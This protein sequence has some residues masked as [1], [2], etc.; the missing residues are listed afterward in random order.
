MFCKKGIFINWGNIPQTELEF[1]PVN[2]FSGGNGS[3]KTTAADGIQ[4]LMTAA[5]ENLFTFNPGQDETTQRGRGGKQVRTLASYILGCDDGSYSR[6]AMTD[7]YVAGLFYPTQGESG[8]PFTAIMCVRAA[9]DRAGSQSQARQVQLFFIILDDC[10][11]SLSDFLEHKESQSHIIPI[12]RIVPHLQKK[13]PNQKMAVFDKKGPYL[14]RLYAAFRGQS[15]S[16]SDR[17]A[18]HAAKTFANFMA[19]KPVKSIH[20]FV[21]KEVL[22]PKD[23]SEDIKLVSE[24]MRTIHGMEIET[25]SL[26]SAINNLTMAMDT[27]ECFIR[28]WIALNLNEYHQA[29]QVYFDKQQRYLAA[30]N[31]QQVL[32]KS[33]QQVSSERVINENK[34]QQIHDELIELEAQRQGIDAL[35]DKDELEKHIDQ[36]QHNLI[37]LAEPL[38]L[39]DQQRIENHQAALAIQ[40]ALENKTALSGFKGIDNPHFLQSLLAMSESKVEQEINAQTLLTKDWV[41][42]S[43][44]ESQLAD[45]MALENIQNQFVHCVIEADSGQLS[46]RDA[47]LTLY[48]QQQDQLTKLKSQLHYRDLEIRRLKQQQINYP[49]GVEVALKALQQYCPEANACVLCD[50]IEVTD[51]NWQMA[52]EGYLG[53]SRFGIIVDTEYEAEAI[54]I[55]RQLK[56]KRNNARVIQSEKVKKD[57]KR[58]SIPANSIVNKMQF[59]HPTAEHY[60]KASFGNVICVDSEQVLRLTARGIMSK[61]LGS[62]GYSLFRCDIDETDWVFGAEARKR[63]LAAKSQQLS[64]QQA[65][66][67][68]TQANIAEV[69]ALLEQFKKIKP[70][71]LSAKV[72]AIL[73][74]YR[75]IQKAENQLKQIDIKDHTDFE[76]N[77]IA[78]KSDYQEV[79]QETKSLT[80][81]MGQYKAELNLTEKSIGAISDEKEALLADKENCEQRL[82]V[83]ADIY[84]DFDVDKQLSELEEATNIDVKNLSVMHQQILLRLDKNQRACIERLAEHNLNNSDYHGI[85]YQ[86]LVEGQPSQD[87]FQAMVDVN[88]EMQRVLHSLKNNLLVDKHDKILSLKESFNTAFVTNLCHSIYQAISAGKRMLTQLNKELGHHRFGA[89]KERFYF[90]YAWVPEFK[91]YHDFFE[92]LIQSPQLG[93]DQT[94][95]DIPLSERSSEVRDKILAML[96]ENDEQLA[97]NDLNRICDY[98]NYRQYEIYK[99]PLDKEPIPLSKYGT[100]SG[101]QLETPAYIIRSAAVTSAF[102][103]NEG[104][105]HCRMVLVDEAF[106]KMDETRSKEVI[107]YLTKTLGLQ[108]VFIMPTS[109]TGPFMDLISHQ[110]IFS[111]CPSK[112]AIGE[113]N[114]RVL[115]DRKVCN[116]DKIA[117]L[118]A[119][120]RKTINQQSSLDFMDEVDTAS[121]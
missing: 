115:L 21:A 89:D 16:L 33:I 46:L 23:L 35:R 119:L 78:L 65:E 36:L 63:S 94:L 29:H 9:L 59:I 41:D 92:E 111:K 2:L 118:W 40:A 37:N 87:Y 10:Q 76:A 69:A 3:G 11:L 71:Q 56:G 97:F 55:I 22:E 28:D 91:E 85:V 47:C 60:I 30:K 113:L 90:D 24:L 27:S 45:L 43:K 15:G 8:E 99:E 42:V 67:N 38:L 103:F 39:A 7:G 108:L 75:K 84:A 82:Y 57:A 120:H 64:Q 13:L 88:K 95:F 49:A 5:Y 107:N 80:E 72:E 77:L 81:K 112:N 79:E 101:G 25:R 17:E 102:R 20:D 51:I 32:A 44:I 34:K 48:T 106:S 66:F 116:Q 61:G 104:E 109:K 117:A 100:G 18:K 52:I 86:S 96:L 26:K 98:R 105:T 1:G 54:N 58:F 62:G 6:P 73:L 121:Y 14:R 114:T 31:Q 19:Y 4:S 83:I 68:L 110:V 74:N 70:L 53:G 93:D 50:F 12:D